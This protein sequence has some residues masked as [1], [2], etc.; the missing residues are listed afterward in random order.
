MNL[1]PFEQHIQAAAH[2]ISDLLAYHVADGNA[3]AAMRGFS[4]ITLAIAWR[5]SAKRHWSLRW[6]LMLML[7]LLGLDALV[8]LAPGRLQYLTVAFVG[9]NIAIPLIAYALARH[10]VVRKEKASNASPGGQARVRQ[11]RVA[12]F[13]ERGEIR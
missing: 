6:G 12:V 13:E 4:V 3:L 5:A 7:V 8:G 9:R 2:W 11:Q 1:S 10:P